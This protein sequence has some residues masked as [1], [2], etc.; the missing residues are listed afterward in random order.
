MN[1]TNLKNFVVLISIV[2]LSACT[3]EA[4]KEPVD[5]VTVQLAWKHQ[6]QFAGFYAADRNGFYEDE[7][8]QATL[9]PRL[10]PTFDVISS[11]VKGAADFGVIHGA[12]LI[13][14]RSKKLPVTAIASIYQSYPLSFISLKKKGIIHPL[15]FVGRSIREL[16]P[17]GTSVIFNMLLKKYKIDAQDINFIR[18]D[19]DLDRF[20]SGEIDIWASYTTNQVLVAR[21]KGVE[22]N[23]IKPDDFG[24][25]MMGDTLF[26]SDMILNT[27]PDLVLRF[28]R[29][30]L[31]GWQWAVEHPEVAA[32][33]ALQFDSKLNP[34]H[35]VA[36]MKGS[37]PYI[38]TAGH[39]GMMDGKVW[40]EM[41]NAILEQGVI[42][43][44]L[45]LNAV[46]T[47]TFVKKIY[48]GR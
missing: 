32:K 23:Q 17:G 26:T 15:D 40:E 39:I 24:I 20:F 7:N 38:Q 1:R 27:N 11:V 12:G 35:Q 25:N 3:G 46:Y 10:C 34:A 31:R 4:M 16:S 37:I 45:N 42:E 41:Y 43:K 36:I 6:A 47:N 28:V 14:A 30:T 9:R 2:F 19:Y 44:P 29:A 21:Q 8:I 5:E 33:M 22:I 18:I 13:A 48:Q